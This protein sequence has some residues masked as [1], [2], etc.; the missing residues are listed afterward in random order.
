VNLDREKFNTA[1]CASAADSIVDAFKH[2]GFL[3][4]HNHGIALEFLHRM[5]HEAMGFFTSDSDADKRKYL[6]SDPSNNFYGFTPWDLSE[7]SFNPDTP[8]D[9]KELFEF[10]PNKCTFPSPVWAETAEELTA[11]FKLLFHR[12]LYLV[13]IGISEGCGDVL[14]SAAA[15]CGEEGNISA[16]R[17]AYYPACSRSAVLPGQ[18]RCGLHCDYDALT[19]IYKPP[20]EKG[21][22]CKLRGGD[23]IDVY[24]ECD[25]D[26]IVN[27]GE[28]LQMFT[29]DVIRAAPH[30]VIWFLPVTEGDDSD[31]YPE[32]FSL[33]FF[34]H[35]DN[36]AVVDTSKIP[37][38][39]TQYEPI[40]SGDYFNARLQKVFVHRIGL[41]D[42]LL[43]TTAD[44]L[45]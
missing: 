28:I 10:M 29:G 23:F 21:L 25:G 26:L 5:K 7:E 38:A 9:A 41:I 13:A 40:R 6:R 36:E 14:E 33:I 16:F 3:V 22:Q 17:A 24:S 4:I 8:L 43:E 15:L 42:E 45:K 44:S 39:V 35:L 34:G 1:S 18:L 27:A 11:M 31:G 30:K 37:G 19:F 12:M 32:K 20:L 2:T